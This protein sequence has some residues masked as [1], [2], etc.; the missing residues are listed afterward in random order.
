MIR[1]LESFLMAREEATRRLRETGLV[2]TTQR[3]AILEFLD[4]V[5]VHPTVDEVFRAVS[6]K[7]P[8]ISRATI[9]NGLR[10]LVDAGLVCELT[11]EKDAARYDRCGDVPHSHFRCSQCGRLFDVRVEQPISVG[12]II[13]GHRVTSVC[14]YLHGVCAC[15]ETEESENADA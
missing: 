9:Y 15:C 6:A 8:S 1:G 10:A 11:I 5:D 13:D 14:T 4:T 3:I 7:H 2:P 12:S